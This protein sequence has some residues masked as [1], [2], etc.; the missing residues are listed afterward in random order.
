MDTH[1]TQAHLTSIRRLPRDLIRS[2]EILLD[3]LTKELRVRYRVAAMGIF[4]AILHPLLMM[5]ILTLVFGFILGP[6]L[7]MGSEARP[8][9]VLLLC[10]LIPWQFFAQ[11]LNNATNALVANRDLIKK[12]YFPREVIPI[13]T[14]LDWTVN[15]A[16][17]VVLL[18]VIHLMF[19]G[20]FGWGTFLFVPLFL[21][22]F[23]L[24][25][26]L[27]LLLAAM[28]VFFRDVKYIV[29]IALAFGFYA[30]PVFY[31]LHFAEENLPGWLYRLYLLNPMAGMIAAYRE[32][33]FD[34]T[35]APKILLWPA[36]T[37]TLAL[38][39]GLY[40]FRRN[41]STMADYL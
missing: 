29:E 28:N 7:N 19:G 27:G 39:V 25:V 33:L 4:W 13:A 37:A 6:R 40:V 26:G 15:F 23:M 9:P 36:C 14:V 32:V 20:V 11:G 5:A 21:V 1:Y 41:A 35:F 24:V 30:T 17:G 8:Y 18:F 38:V 10:G 31:E 16:I 34:G 2:R 22:Q 3:L 12:V